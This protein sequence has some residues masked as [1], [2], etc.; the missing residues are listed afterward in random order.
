MSDQ[1]TIE[2]FNHL[3]GL[4]ALELTE[5]QAEYLRKQLNNQ[6]KVIQELKAIPLDENVPI[7]LHGVPYE[8]ENSVAPREDIWKPYPDPEAILAQAPQME[9]GYII[10]PDI[11][12]TTLK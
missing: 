5:E 7:S 4:A 10:V 8:K 12:H 11:P 2:V 1:I 6:L 9:D 3:V